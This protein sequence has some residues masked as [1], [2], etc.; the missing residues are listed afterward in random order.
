MT[1]YTDICNWLYG[2]AQSE[3]GRN[4]E[5]ELNGVTVLVIQRREDADRVLRRNAD[6]Y[7]KNMA[8]FRQALGASRFSE[9][10]VAWQ[11]RKDLTQ[12]YFNKFDRQTTFE[13]A[14]QHALD[15]VDKLAAASAAEVSTLDDSTLRTLTVSV[16]IENFFGIRLQDM[17]IDIQNMASLMEFGSE[18]SFVPAG[19]TG[20]LYRESL[21]RLP[22]LRR[23]VFQDFKHF[24]EQGFAA[25]PM[26]QGMLAADRD[27]ANNI[28]LEHELLTFF[29]A[30]AETTAATLGWACYLLAANPEVQAQLRDEV[31]SFW[32]EPE[33]SRQRLSDLKGLRTFISETL[34]LYPPTPIIA[35]LAVA[36]DRLGEQVIQPGQNVLISFIGIQHDSQFCSDPWSLRLDRHRSHNEESG[37]GIGTA[38]SFGP[39]MCG[40]KQFALVELAAFLCVFLDRAEFELLSPEPPSFH[41]KSQ[42]LRQGGQPVKVTLLE[43]TGA[44]SS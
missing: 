42:M 36:Q 26:L 29:A 24:R 8:W 20:T 44:R 27:P 6:N 39:R 5:A 34:R 19:K 25:N 23:Q 7:M 41:W 12:Y 40:G 1:H 10:G 9:D 38:F 28:V 18:Y 2:I 4:V 16:L 22:G 37:S 32:N 33:G 13:L 31:R 3:E 15:A 35:R 11:I 21:K 17:Q 43:R 14:R 30:G